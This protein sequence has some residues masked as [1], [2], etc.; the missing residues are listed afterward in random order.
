MKLLFK[1]P[2]LSDKNA[3]DCITREYGEGSC[4]HSFVT[5]YT[6]TEKYNDEIFLHDNMLYVHR[7][8]LDT[9]EY[10]VY[11][12]PLGGGDLKD[13]MENLMED[14]HSFGKKMQIFT[15][16][17]QMTERIRELYADQF[18]YENI[19]DYAEYLYESEQ[20]WKMPGS[21]NTRKRRRVRQFHQFAPD[22][23]VKIITAADTDALIRYHHEWTEKFQETHDMAALQA[24]LN[25]MKAQFRYFDELEIEGFMVIVEGR[26]RGYC[27]GC[28]VS[29]EVFDAIVGKGDY[30]FPNIYG[31]MYQQL[32][33]VFQKYH[34]INFEEDLGIEGL[35]TAKT[36]YR[37]AKMLYKYK[38]TEA[39]GTH[40]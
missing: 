10:R 28:D 2:E 11:L 6:H 1:K 21:E 22:A 17:E 25:M 7:S 26:I 15:A 9:D 23:Q 27:Y 39:G 20:L 14:A 30:Y 40:E 36:S 31:F 18:E 35:R 13:A 32:G 24:E 19:R 37:P 12:A 33:E 29:S 34:Y 5:F 8:G 4:Q 16:T 3:V 38:I